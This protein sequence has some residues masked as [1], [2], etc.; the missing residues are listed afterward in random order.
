[1]SEALALVELKS[2]ARGIVTLDA[3]TKRACVTPL[4]SE[5]VSPGKFLLLFSGDV[6][7]VEEAFAA[8]LNAG[9]DLVLDTLHLPDAHPSL[10]PLLRGQTSPLA[11]DTALGIQEFATVGAALRT[12]D[13][14][15]KGTGV[16]AHKLHLARGIGGKAYFV[17]G[18][19]LAD[20]EAAHAVAALTTP[21]DAV[22]ANEIIARLS[23]DVALSHL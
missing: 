5:A 4:L 1:M 17:V 23:P 12:L 2:I 6:A 14:V 11:E 10:L 18:G 22:L 20:V 16:V 8:A 7:S 3:L 21:Q 9:A 13:R 15:L 19:E